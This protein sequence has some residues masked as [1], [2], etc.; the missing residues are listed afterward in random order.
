[1]VAEAV[2][3]AMETKGEDSIHNL[4]NS[5]D[6]TAVHSSAI[7]I[8]S[9]SIPIGTIVI[10]MGTIWAII[11]IIQVPLAIILDTITFGQQLG[12]IHVEDQ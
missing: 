9:K 2:D 8:A 5:R 4:S 10:P 7:P 11:I 1:M 3:V 6:T 12:T